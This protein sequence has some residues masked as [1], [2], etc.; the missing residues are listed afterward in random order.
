MGVRNS[1]GALEAG[2]GKHVSLNKTKQASGHKVNSRIRMQHGF[3]FSLVCPWKGREGSPG[4]LARRRAERIGPQDTLP[5][6]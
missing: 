3:Y 4:T 1:E 2:L 5:Q 6:L